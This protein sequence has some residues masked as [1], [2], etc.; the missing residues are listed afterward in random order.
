[1]GDEI[2]GLS[3]NFVTPSKLGKKF[4]P[5]DNFVTLMT[6]Q[7]FKLTKAKCRQLL[8]NLCFVAKLNYEISII[9]DRHIG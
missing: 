5:S 2:T 8:Q 9:S 3:A 6:F 1:M 7:Q 4:I